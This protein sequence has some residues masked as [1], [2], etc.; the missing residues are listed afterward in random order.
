MSDFDNITV[1][2]VL[3]T[4]SKMDGFIHN[5]CHLNLDNATGGAF[6]Q[7]NLALIKDGVLLISNHNTDNS[8][9]IRIA[10]KPDAKWHRGCQD[11][12]AHGNPHPKLEEG[13]SWVTVWD[14]KMK[15]GPWEPKIC[16]VIQYWIYKAIEVENAKL[17]AAKEIRIA[18]AAKKAEFDKELEQNWS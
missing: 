8:C 4:R 11:S 2:S 3:E 12:C 15:P 16:E 18:T 6:R 5:L 14:G 17:V 1:D 13:A 7:V 9:Y 10:S